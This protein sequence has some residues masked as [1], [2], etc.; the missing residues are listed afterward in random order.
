MDIHLKSLKDK[1]KSYINRNKEIDNTLHNSTSDNQEEILSKEKQDNNNEI[2]KARTE[3]YEIEALNEDTDYIKKSY[4]YLKKLGLV[5]SQHQFSTYYL[6]KSQHYMSMIL[7]EGRR[8]A[9]NT[10]YNLLQN[11][12]LTYDLYQE[13]DKNEVVGRNLI[14]LIERGDKILNKRIL[15]YYRRLE[16]F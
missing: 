10:L 2:R 8:P 16:G 6:N 1:I 3:K 15:G 14:S 12:N 9:V 7:C 4:Q 5:K 13:Y 11:L